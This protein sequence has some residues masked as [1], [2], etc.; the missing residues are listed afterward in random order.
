MSRHW[1]PARPNVSMVISKRHIVLQ[2]HELTRDARLLGKLDELFATLRLLD[3]AGPGEQRIEIA[4]SSDQLGR[5]LD[6]DARDAR[7][8]VD[9]VARQAPARR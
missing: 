1:D 6:A 2:R 4:I 5:R 8:V 7:H 9:G 3:L